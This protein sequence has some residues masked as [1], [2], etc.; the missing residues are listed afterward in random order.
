MVSLRFLHMLGIAAIMIFSGCG[1][2]D[3][4]IA[5]TE[6]SFKDMISEYHDNSIGNLSNPKSGNPAVYIDASDCIVEA[7]KA[8]VHARTIKELATEF[9]TDPSI[10]F[11]GLGVNNY[12]GVGQIAGDGSAIYARIVSPIKDIY[13]PIDSALMR[14]ADA[15]NDGLLVS[16]FELLRNNAGKKEEDFAPYAENHFKKWIDAGNSITVF[17]APYTEQGAAKNLYYLFFNHGSVSGK[18][19]VSH[20]DPIAQRQGLKRIEINPNVYQV[21]NE[22]GGKTLTGL[23]QDDP[24]TT[25]LKLN[26]QS[27]VL[28]SYYNGFAD[29][30]E[31]YEALEFQMD[32]PG[33]FE[34]YFKDNKK[35]AGKVFLNSGVTNTYGLKGVEVKVTDVTDDFNHYSHCKEAKQHK[36]VL[37]KDE[38]KNNIWD[39]KTI[40]DPIASECYE[41]NT[42]KLK[43]EY[44]YVYK[45]TDSISEYFELDNN[46]FTQHLQ[47]SPQQIEL[48]TIFHKQFQPG[49]IDN[50]KEKILRLDLVVGDVSIASNPDL[51]NLKWGS[52]ITKGTFNESLYQSVYKTIRDIS[53]KGRRLYSYYVKFSAK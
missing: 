34:N 24:N 38:G 22:Y 33:L 47:N 17:Y 29:K 44:M 1:G 31:P 11:F 41:E 43:Q 20:F 13:A 52:I 35:F 6:P 53:P 32:L 39:D 42:Q 12:Q 37:T 9:A 36:P 45:A 28:N 15:Q 14:M 8:P 30:Q 18:S 26:D 10:M 19:L 27:Q 4:G 48:R 46:L 7:L 5:W 23:M 51:E 2:G 49:N 50:S 40:Q 21:T 25:D 3:A 16:D